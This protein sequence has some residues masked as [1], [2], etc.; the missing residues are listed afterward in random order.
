MPF[1][2]RWAS[3]LFGTLSCPRVVATGHKHS[4]WFGPVVYETWPDEARFLAVCHHLQR[5][6]EDPLAE[7][8]LIES[9][10]QHHGNA[11][12]ALLALYDVIQSR[13]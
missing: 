11:R 6:M 13:D 2:Q 7:S 9:W 12:E 5:G 8:E 1:W 10:R 3:R 4:P